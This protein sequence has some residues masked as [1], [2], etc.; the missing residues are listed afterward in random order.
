MAI[1]ALSLLIAIAA[2]TAR[3][4]PGLLPATEV[5]EA[6]TASSGEAALAARGARQRFVADHDGSSARGPSADTRSDDSTVPRD[7]RIDVVLGPGLEGIESASVR[8]HRAGASRPLPWR[9]LSLDHGR[10]PIGWTETEGEP[11]VALDIAVDHPR[12]S[13]RPVR[14]SPAEAADGVLTLR[15]PPAVPVRGTATLATE[16]GANVSVY[17]FPA[18]D[19]VTTACEDSCA[20]ASGVPFELRLRDGVEYTIIAIAP[21][22]APVQCNVRAADGVV[23]GPLTCGPGLTISGAIERVGFGMEAGPLTLRFERCGVRRTFRL[24]DGTSIGAF[25]DGTLARSRGTVL[26]AADGSFRISGLAP[27]AHRLT[28]MA[29]DATLVGCALEPSSDVAPS[30]DP[31]TLVLRGTEVEV[32]APGLPDGAPIFA[33]AEGV[34]A[35]TG[36]TV[37]NERHRFIAPVG[38]RLKFSAATGVMQRSAERPP[39]HLSSRVELAAPTISFA[40]V[41]LERAEQGEGRPGGA[42]C[43][44]RAEDGRKLFVSEPEEFVDGRAVVRL[45]DV[46]R[47]ELVVRPWTRRES[48][49]RDWWV[50]E[51]RKIDTGARPVV[52][53]NPRQGGRLSI[54]SRDT[55]GRPFRGRVRLTGTAGEVPIQ[56][57]IRID[58]TVAAGGPFLGPE[59]VTDLV[60][61]ILPGRYQVTVTASDGRE[62]VL[63]VSLTSGALSTLR[64][65]GR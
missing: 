48:R 12:A 39:G 13:R 25:E 9:Q 23:A 65:A 52:R 11:V 17:A 16:S 8:E 30:P 51:S 18:T 42:T 38:T 14:I 35:T 44:L 43:E 64:V 6:A 40:D 58:G 49:H 19:G 37:A 45:P 56:C 4:V 29:R 3:G 2:F 63:D 59:G 55:E 60:D 62:T 36:G 5:R 61:P 7:R 57:E 31:L 27:G 1:G 46:G 21:D 10:L 28:A 54:I 53:L 24:P 47:A 15:I 32:V 20:A 41:V 33:D 22:C 50:P 34:I 26:V